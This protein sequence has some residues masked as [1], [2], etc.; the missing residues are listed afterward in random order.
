MV[1]VW[2]NDT[3]YFQYAR[4]YTSIHAIKGKGENLGIIGN[5]LKEIGPTSVLTQSTSNTQVSPIKKKAIQNTLKKKTLK[6]L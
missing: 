5:S 3:A 1:H 4:L 6:R 2:D